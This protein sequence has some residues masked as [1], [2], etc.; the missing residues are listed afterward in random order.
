MNDPRPR[1]E[2]VAL[3]GEPQ[4]RACRGQGVGK[5][6]DPRVGADPAPAFG[7]GGTGGLH[8]RPAVGEDHDPA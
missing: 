5:V 3:R 4:G 6:E 8:P 1:V 7:L 2:I